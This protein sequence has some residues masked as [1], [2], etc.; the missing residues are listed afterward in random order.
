MIHYVTGNLLK[1]QAQALVNTVNT[2]GVMGKGIALQFKEAFPQNYSEY[3]KVCKSGELQPG[4][5]LIF[6][7][8]T[9][10]GARTII[11]FP[12]K[13]DWRKKSTYKIIES[14][15]QELRKQ[16]EVKEI[17]SLALPPLGCGLGGL[18]WN[19]V[20]PLIE[21]YLGDLNARIEV[22]E[23][24]SAIKAILQKEHS[25]EVK[26]TPARAMLLYTL[27][28]YESMGEKS[29][30]FA[31]NKMAYFLQE[32]GQ[33]LRLNF[34][35]RFYGPYSLGVEKVLYSLNGK[36]MKGLEQ[37]EAQAFE[38]LK[39]DYSRLEEVTQY[40]SNVLA[41]EE[42]KRLQN[43]VQFIMGFESTFAIELL[44]SVSFLAKKNRLR[45]AEEVYEALQNWSQRKADM[46][47]LRHVEI[48][49]KHLEKYSTALEFS[50]AV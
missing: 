42:R 22:F 4:T 30:L 9:L 17:K 23:P 5:L 3:L 21:R 18:D 24:N 7:E 27:F 36:Y 2:V 29:S 34:V 15:L 11:N 26:L 48:A 8:Q 49:W 25:K 32:M 1:S 38:E 20:K 46:F 44:S 6:E 37:G 45:S 13:T 14:G 40:I 28:Q 19:I 10:N 16:T 43:L 31:A 47:K 12:T 39:L 35:A 41:P 50:S 33:P